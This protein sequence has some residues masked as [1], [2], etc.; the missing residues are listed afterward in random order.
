M[1]FK[2]KILLSIIALPFAGVAL[3]AG[4]SIASDML[5]AQRMSVWA[6]TE[7]QLV[8]AGY[9]THTGD[10]ATH[11]AY[12]TYRYVVQGRTYTGHR[13]AIA[14]GADNIG[15]FQRRTGA[16]LA[17]MQ[18]RGQPVTVY[19]DPGAPGNA[20][21]DRQLRWEMIG[22]KAI[23][24]LVFGAVGFGLLI[25]VLRAGPP[26]DPE[27]PAYADAPWLAN[28]AWQTR[29]LRSHS[30]KTMWT[31]WAVTALW[32]LISAPL[33]FLLYGEI[34][35]KQNY[36]AL[37]ILLFPLV[38]IGLVVYA[39][40]CT[41]EWRRFGPAPVTLDPFPG[42]IGGHVGGTIDLRLPFDTQ[43]RFEVTLTNLKSYVSGSGKNRSRKE[44]ALWQDDQLVAADP[45][46]E[47]TRIV[48]RFDVPEGQY[49]SDAVTQG[50]TWFLWRLNVTAD[51]PGAD[52]DRSYELPVYPT[53][54]LSASL[55]DASVE[56]NRNAQRARSEDDARRLLNL[57]RSGASQSLHFP[58]GRYL[59]AAATGLF[60][61][62]IFVGG[63]WYIMTQEGSLFGGALFAT[64]GGLVAAFLLYLGLNSLTV[65]REGLSLTAVRR[66]LGVPVST[67]RMR[68]DDV[69]RLSADSLLQTQSGSRHVMH[70]RILAHGADGQTMTVGEGFRGQSDADAAM[71]LIAREF[72]LR[73]DQD[74]GAARRD[75]DVLAVDH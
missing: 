45:G 39:I 57:R 44:K 43:S 40:R 66:V 71:R 58:V 31:A 24:L 51:L 75:E 10:S 12:A 25:F 49:A 1:K 69:L 11:E 18:S 29:E 16:R 9:T 14:G 50:D 21:I 46:P 34:V 19:Y 54:E 7:A 60:F 30:R 17:A 64:V 13:V 59:G 3:W 37:V 23:F 41:R 27:D 5:A 28:D 15:D 63:G 38:G 70:Y 52:F 67:R 32:N 22:F 53:G 62:I 2:G 42:A 6:S 36:P 33:P 47:G 61:G 20:V 65:T 8:E 35:D 26:K 55:P 72:G 68:I 56:R 74:A 4:Y 48:F 73:V